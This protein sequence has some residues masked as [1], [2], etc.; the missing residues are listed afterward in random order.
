MQRIFKDK[1]YDP[2]NFL[3]ALIANGVT[4]HCGGMSDPFQPI[5]EKLKVTNRIID[6]TPDGVVDR[7]TT[8]DD[9]LANE[10]VKQQLAEKYG[11]K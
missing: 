5:N 2:H 8:Y 3:D 10:T 4:W 6:I 11:K 7:V 9:F 1:D